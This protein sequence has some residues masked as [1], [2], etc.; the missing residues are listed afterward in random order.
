MTLSDFCH[1]V[2]Q[3]LELDS[4]L[5]GPLKL[6]VASR[7]GFQQIRQHL[8]EVVGPSGNQEVVKTVN[9][10]PAVEVVRRHHLIQRPHGT[11]EGSRVFLA[12][13]FPLPFMDAP[14]ERFFEHHL[15][16]TTAAVGHQNLDVLSVVEKVATCEELEGEDG[17]S[18]V[19]GGDVGDVAQHA[20]CGVELFCLGDA[21]QTLFDHDSRQRRH[22]NMLGAASQ[23]L[24][25]SRRRVGREDEPRAATAFLHHSSQVGL[26]SMTEVVGVFDDDDSR[27][28]GKVAGRWRRGFLAGGRRRSVR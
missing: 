1:A 12:L 13:S 15:D 2:E 18:K 26:A 14:A 19:P 25:D 10:A 21:F 9:D 5:C 11:L 16:L 24:D 6:H 3:F 27:Y 8:V 4:F 23:R 28:S 20:L 17:L 7:D 22:A